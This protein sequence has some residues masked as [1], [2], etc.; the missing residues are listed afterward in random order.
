M[1]SGPQ[2]IVTLTAETT[3]LAFALGC[4]DRIVGVT[5]Y[6]VRPPEA[7]K[8]PHVA[9]FQTAHAQRILALEPDLVIGFS[10]LQAEIAR[11][12]IKGGAQVLITNQRTIAQTL[13]AIGIVAGALGEP[14]VGARLAA[15]LEAELE[16]IAS[17]ARASAA[18]P[19]VFFEEWDEPLISG[20][21]WVSE[22][23]ELCGGRDIFPELRTAAEASGRIVDA[24]EAARRDPE[25]ILASWCGKKVRPE[26]IRARPG[27]ADVS[28][29]RAGR[30][31]EI[32]SPD[33]LAPGLSLVHGA[34][35]I[36]AALAAS[37]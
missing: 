16:S 22:I 14:E 19:R 9:A 37:G 24:L 4:A 12:L 25:V 28:A 26:R 1:A 31:H 20:I 23:V 18:R 35:A 13:E 3:E 32:K 15:R 29:I 21:A 8:K 6:A 33:I 17:P 11:E 5:G 27:W 10:D 34:R 7:R 36:A 2:R 30:I